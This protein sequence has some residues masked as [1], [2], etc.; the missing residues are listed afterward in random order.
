MAISIPDG[1]ELLAGRTRKNAAKALSMA[2]ER[3][4]PASA[5]RTHPEG[6]LIPEG[7][8]KKAAPKAAS[9]TEEG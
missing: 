4:V 9:K 6:Y 7:T 3:G 5:V 2:E 8:K 1:H